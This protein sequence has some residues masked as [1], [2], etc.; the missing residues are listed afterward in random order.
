MTGGSRTV[1]ITGA[2]GY[3]GGIIGERMRVGGWKT[4]DL[5]RTKKGENCRFFSIAGPHDPD[6]LVGV[7]V[8]VHCAY[9]MSLR[10][11]SDIWRVNVE[12]TR[13]LLKLAQEAGVR[14]IILLSSMSAFDGTEQIYGQSKLQIEEDARLFG[15]CSIR[16]GLVYGPR[17]GGMASTLARLARLPVVP[18]ITPHSYQFTLHEDDLAEVVEAL[19]TAE[20]VSA[21]PIGVANPTPVPFRKILERFAREQ[22]H[23][24]RFLPI[25]W[26]VVNNL[27]RLAERLRLPLPVRADSLLGLVRPAP[28]VPN[29]AALESLGIQLRRFGQPV[30]PGVK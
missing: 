15:A 16:P 17:G 11:R 21:D 23:R 13:E 29:L 10:Q 14:R 7:D 6:L 1:A 30:P 24:C 26:R 18:L 9:D 27:L 3:L 28:F 12:G 20:R 2:N 4:I 22:G 5:I 25:N 19:A 8:L